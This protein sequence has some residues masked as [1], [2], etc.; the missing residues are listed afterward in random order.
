M[1]LVGRSRKPPGS[2]GNEQSEML[3]TKLPIVGW[4]ASGL[5]GA[6]AGV[7]AH[8]NSL[9]RRYRQ[10]E[11]YPGATSSRRLSRLSFHEQAFKNISVQDRAQ[12]GADALQRSIGSGVYPY[13]FVLAPIVVIISVICQQVSST[14]CDDGRRAG[15]RHVSAPNTPAGDPIRSSVSACRVW[16]LVLAA[17]WCLRRQM[18]QPMRSAMPRMDR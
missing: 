15:Q 14:G 2:Q 18:D 9:C 13:R 10:A 7:G 3:T 17:S 11:P 5:R 16:W 12:G 6:R 1:V 8:V 4:S